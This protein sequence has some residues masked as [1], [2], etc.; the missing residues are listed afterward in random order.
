MAR[1]FLYFIAICIALILAAGIL[2][3]RYA[4]RILQYTSVPDVAFVEQEKL[5][6]NVYDDPAMWFARPGRRTSVVNWLPPG[7][8]PMGKGDA[9]VFFIH[10]TSYLA[11]DYWNAPL[12]DVE[13]Q[14][15]AG[16][17]LRGM[18]SAFNAAG[19][20][21]APRYRQ[22]AFGAFITDKPE[23][24]KAID[25]AYQDVLQAFDAF[26]DGIGQDQ[27]IIL[28]GHSQGSLHLTHLMKDRIAGKPLAKRIVAAYVVGWPISETTDLPALGLPQCETADQPGC[29]LSWLSYAEPADVGFIEKA[30]A[31]TTGFDGQSRSGTTMVCTNP[32]TGHADD[33][34]PIEANLG[35]LVPNDDLSDAELV[36]ASVPARCDEKGFLLIGDPPSLGS[37]VL[38]GNNYHVY[39]YPLFWANV[40]ADVAR[41][42][43]AFEAR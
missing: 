34:A 39:D 24:Q 32:L 8:Q 2:W 28:A 5:A 43:D 18:A 10:P 37:Y 36:P 26:L 6:E 15:R 12:D 30:Y 23:G 11:K 9:A 29:V 16:V 21:W 1:K 13:S 41:R 19:D 20:V 3:S 38:P 22:A 42:L 4:D 17:F 40:R 31:A 35:T 7:M 25:A 14:N 33:E 27:P